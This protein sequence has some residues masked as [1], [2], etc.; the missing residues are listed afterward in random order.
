M[1]ILYV[2]VEKIV[3]QASNVEPI[4]YRESYFGVVYNIFLYF[5]IKLSSW[6][7]N[8]FMLKDT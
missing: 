8:T 6:I 7:Y 3:C 5:Y 4:F 2:Y 1:I